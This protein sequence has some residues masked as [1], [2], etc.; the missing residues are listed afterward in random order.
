MTSIE[1]G[2]VTEPPAPSV[3]AESELREKNQITMPKRVADVL[4][5]RAGDRFIWVV[6][7]GGRGVIHLHRL[8]SGYAA[9]LAG[10]YGRPDE[11]DAYLA[12][13]RESW[14]E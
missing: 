9:S 1:N 13:E 6:E 11:V 10:V 7:D 2:T 8:P 5:A 3:E 12:A 14:D 4:K